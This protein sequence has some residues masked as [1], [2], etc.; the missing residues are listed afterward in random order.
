[1]HGCHNSLC[2]GIQERSVFKVILPGSKDQP[3]KDK[4]LRSCGRIQDHLR[5][6]IGRYRKKYN[7]TA[8]CICIRFLRYVR[9]DGLVRI[10]Q[11]PLK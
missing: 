3:V 6:G 10:N 2:Q 9:K 1:M 5:D 4:R 8:R 11:R 7:A